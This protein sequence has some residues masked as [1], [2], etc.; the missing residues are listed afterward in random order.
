MT[1]TAA[2]DG[3]LPDFLSYIQVDRL[4]PLNSMTSLVIMALLFMIYGDVGTLINYSSFLNSLYNA[5]VYLALIIFRFKTFKNVKRVIKVP[6]LIPVL[7]FLLNI[8][9]FIAPL[10]INP[11]IEFVYFGGGAL[12]LSTIIYLMFVHFKLSPPFYDQCVTQLQLILRLA[13]PKRFE[14]IQ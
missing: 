8:Y 10:A 7:M 3:N 4:V 5:G 2:R 14:N 6:L 9:L 12:A 13:P 11:Q 1:F